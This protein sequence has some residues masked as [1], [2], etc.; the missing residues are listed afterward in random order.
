MESMSQ[1]QVVDENYEAFK[2]KLPELLRTHP[3]KFALMCDRE[4]VAIFD[5]SQDAIEA[6]NRFLDGNFSVQQIINRP[7]DLGFFSHVGI[8]RAV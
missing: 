8:S 5:T 3:N 4:V 6:G 2:A 7:F 1:Q